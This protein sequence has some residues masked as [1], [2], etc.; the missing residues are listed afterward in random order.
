MIAVASNSDIA[1]PRLALDLSQVLEPDQV[2]RVPGKGGSP[3]VVANA[4]RLIETDVGFDEI[5]ARVEKGQEC[6]V[7]ESDQELPDGAV[8]LVV[9]EW[10]TALD[11]PEVFFFCDRPKSPRRRVRK[12]A[13][14][15]PAGEAPSS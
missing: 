6:E 2:Y 8:P 5:D 9:I 14:L 7:F 11:R 1:N 4:S 10:T 12:V 15:V 3:E 13:A